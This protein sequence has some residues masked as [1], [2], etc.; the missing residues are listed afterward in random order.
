[1]GR[2]KLW[3]NRETTDVRRDRVLKRRILEERAK[4]FQIWK[5]ENSKT[6]SQ[7]IVDYLKGK[8][9][10]HHITERILRG[11]VFG[12]K[13]NSMSLFPKTPEQKYFDVIGQIRISKLISSIRRNPKFKWFSI[14]TE[15]A[16]LNPDTQDLEYVIYDFAAEQGRKINRAES[17]VEWET[18]RREIEDTKAEITTETIER[19]LTPEAERRRLE[20]EEKDRRTN[21]NSEDEES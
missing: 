16:S 3:K 21:N 5:R 19:A 4:A 7:K 2:K 15:I 1:M 12:P 9:I 6:I 8:K 11:V 17:L 18:N 10:S 20:R 14:S 13:Y